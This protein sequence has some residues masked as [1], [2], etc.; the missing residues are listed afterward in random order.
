MLKTTTQNENL[1]ILSNTNT[2]VDLIGRKTY[3]V[4]E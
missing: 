4:L 2:K 3:Y 1:K